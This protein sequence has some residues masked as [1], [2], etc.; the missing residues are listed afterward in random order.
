M[1]LPTSIEKKTRAFELYL[2]NT[3]TNTEI[4]AS[5]GIPLSTIR[6]WINDEGWA[7]KKRQHERNLMQNAA[8]AVRKFMENN[9]LETLKR[10][11]EVSKTLE[12]RILEKLNGV[13]PKTGKPYFLT[14]RDIATLAKALKDS[15]DVSARAAGINENMLNPLAGS[16]L[17][18]V[19]GLTPRRVHHDSGG[20]PI[21]VTEVVAE[22]D[23][24]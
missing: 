17:L 23:P 18:V 22:P 13:N 4:A 2:S 3:H 19:P 11:L 24:F 6:F 7:E 12:G 16:T 5:T 20:Q 21:E 8:S 15:A 10:H 9:Q 1:A 14:E